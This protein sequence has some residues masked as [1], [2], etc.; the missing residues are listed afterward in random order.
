[1]AK[2][3]MTRDEINERKKIEAEA[4]STAGR[5]MQLV[6][7]VVLHDQLGFDADQL[8]E[9]IELFGQALE[10]YN[11][12]NDYRGLLEQWNNYFVD[13]AGIDIMRKDPTKRTTGNVK[14]V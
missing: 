5:C 13:Y 6:T 7:M 10:Y 4:L 8:N 2:R 11:D 3:Y 14:T 9:F 12:S 1:M